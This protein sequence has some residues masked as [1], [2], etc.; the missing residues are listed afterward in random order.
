MKIGLYGPTANGGQHRTGSVPQR[1]AS[2]RLPHILGGVFVLLVLLLR[3][4]LGSGLSQAETLTTPGGAFESSLA[5][6]RYALTVSLADDQ[7]LT[8]SRAIAEFAA[9]DVAYLGQGRFA[10]MF[11][12]GVA[13]MALPFYIAGRAFGAGQLFT[14]FVPLLLTIGNVYLA[15]RVLLAFDFPRSIRLFT[16]LLLTLATTVLPYSTQLV[17]HQVSLAVALAMVWLSRSAPNRTRRCILWGIAALSLAFDW[18]NGVV[19]LPFLLLDMHRMVQKHGKIRL[20]SVVRDLLFLVSAVGIP[21]TGFALYNSVAN[22]NPFQIG[23]FAPSVTQFPNIFSWVWALLFSHVGAA[24]ELSRIPY[25]L[26]VLGLSMERGVLFFAPVMLFSLW[27]LAP[28]WKM[29]RDI[30]L[31]ILGSIIL[32]VSLYSAFGDVWGGPSFGPRYLIPVF[33]LAVPFL[34]AAI[35]EQRKSRLFTVIFTLAVIWSVAINMLGAVSTVLLPGSADMRERG[36]SVMYQPVWQVLETG[37][38]GSFVYQLGLRFVLPG[39]WFYGMMVLCS[40]GILVPLWITVFRQKH[41]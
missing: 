8:F 5:R 13:L 26:W 20:Q 24:F 17:Q 7:S 9:P 11:P 32:T 10:S 33:G 36:V 6:G 2:F 39:V 15:Y 37:T 31:A 38:L 22:G 41:I 3:G 19:V 14:M 40:L 28:L 35:S 30:T 1:G 18:P 16:G 27:G 21:L 4:T 12:P 25:G 29:Q 23:Q 34:A